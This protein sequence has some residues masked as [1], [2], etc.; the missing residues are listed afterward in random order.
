[1]KRIR[2]GLASFTCDE[3]CSIAFLEVLNK[4]FADWE[5]SIDISY[6]RILRSKNEL[7]NLDVVFVEGA[8]SNQK[9]VEKLKEIRKN[10]RILVAIGSCAINGSPSNIRN[11]LDKERMNEIKPILKKFN[12]RDKVTGLNEIVK[13]DNSVPGCPMDDDKFIEVV[14]KYIKELK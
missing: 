8:I 2:V 1:M 7:K 6:S 9:E 3:G 12:Y 5:K 11:F 4:K 14:E 13:V 10:T